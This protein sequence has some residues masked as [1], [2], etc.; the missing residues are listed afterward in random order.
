MC[1]VERMP[2][3]GAKTSVLPRQ[4]QV[5]RVN[6][7]CTPRLFEEEKQREREGAVEC[8]QTRENNVSMQQML[9][10]RPGPGCCRTRIPG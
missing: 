1:V 10:A 7:T 8:E 2:G 4:S 5:G 6:S 3:M 9:Q